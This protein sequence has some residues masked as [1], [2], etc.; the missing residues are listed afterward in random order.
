MLLLGLTL[1]LKKPLWNWTKRTLLSGKY[2]GSTDKLT[3]S[4]NLASEQKKWQGKLFKT[5]E[6]AEAA[7]ISWYSGWADKFGKAKESVIG[8]VD[9]IQ[10]G[11]NVIDAWTK[12]LTGVVSKEQ[13]ND[14]DTKGSSTGF[15]SNTLTVSN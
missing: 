6:D 3:R 1:N 8:D 14:G 4:I 10:A 7:V 12:T 15:K 13:G 9:P 5:S 2:K 11:Q